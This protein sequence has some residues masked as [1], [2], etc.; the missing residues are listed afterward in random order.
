MIM[1]SCPLEG[2]SASEKGTTR[3]VLFEYSLPE[4]GGDSGAEDKGGDGE[5]NWARCVVSKLL[6]DW[7]SVCKLYKHAVELDTYL[8]GT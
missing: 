8:K 1:D 6:S 5:E 3:H 7:C 2:V 4:G